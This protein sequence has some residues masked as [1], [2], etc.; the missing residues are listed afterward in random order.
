MAAS[1]DAVHLGVDGDIILDVVDEFKTP[2]PLTY[3]SFSIFD[4]SLTASSKAHRRTGPVEG[5]V[6]ERAALRLWYGM[7]SC[8]CSRGGGSVM[9]DDRRFSR[10]RGLLR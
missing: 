3:V 4:E 5:R 10:A 1:M 7:R 9:Q 6:N 8:T 2:L